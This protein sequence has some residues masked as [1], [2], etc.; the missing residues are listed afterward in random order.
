MFEKDEDYR[1]ARNE[2]KAFI[3]K[4]IKAWS[5]REET[6]HDEGFKEGVKFGYNRANEWHYPSKG[7][8][9]KC[10]AETIKRIVLGYYRKP[11]LIKDGMVFVEKS[12]GYEEEHLPQSVIAWKEI[13]LPEMKESE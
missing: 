12:R 8:Y 11:F 1:K 5:A 2:S 10:D 6:L 7:E 4:V 13:V 3:T 9:P